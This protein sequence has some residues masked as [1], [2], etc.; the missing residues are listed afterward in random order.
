MAILHTTH[1]TLPEKNRI[2]IIE[3]L[4]K[5][6]ASTADLQAQ[7]KQAHWNIKGP[8][9]ISLHELFDKLAEEVEGHVDVIAERITSLG[10]TARGTLQE[11]VNNSS[12]NPYPVDIFEAKDHIEHLS[13]N[14][15]ILGE[16]A[17]DNMVETER[18]GDMAT[19]DIYVDLARSLD[20]GLWF[21][22]AHVQR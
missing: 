3:V 17:R 2:E 18:L 8:Q 21:I 1:M 9:F 19:N 4:N 11:A 6:L 16:L 20:K 12:L 15:A 7:L 5:S 10:G 22:E 14:F 13:Q